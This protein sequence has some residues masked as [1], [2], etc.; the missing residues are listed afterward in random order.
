MAIEKELTPE[1]REEI[2]TMFTQG[3]DEFDI[4]DKIINLLKEK[5]MSESDAEEAADD[6]YD[7][8][9]ESDFKFKD[10][11]ELFFKYGG[12]PLTF[13]MLNS[14][15]IDTNKLEL[16]LKKLKITSNIEGKDE[17]GMIT[18]FNFIMYMA[19]EVKANPDIGGMLNDNIDNLVTWAGEK[20]E[21]KES[22]EV[23]SKIRI[24]FAKEVG[25]LPLGNWSNRKAMYEYWA[26]IDEKYSKVEE[27]YGKL[28][29]EIKGE[30]SK[31]IKY[32]VKLNPMKLDVPKSWHNA[33]KILKYFSELQGVYQVPR[34]EGNV[35]SERIPK[36]VT[37]ADVD[38]IFHYYY[39]KDY[40][41]LA[42]PQGQIDEIKEWIE[43]KQE[44]GKGVVAGLKNIGVSQSN[45]NEFDE[46]FEDF[47]R[48]AGRDEKDKT[49]NYFLPISPFVER[50]NDEY[51]NINT[52]LDGF[53]EELDKIL[54]PDEK[55]R[56]KFTT[57]QTSPSGVGRGQ[58]PATTQEAETAG[59]IMYPSQMGSSLEFSAEERKE[60]S[61]FYD[62][63]DAINEYYLIPVSSPY[64]VQQKEKPRWVKKHAAML[65][66]LISGFE[67]DESGE[68]KPKDPVGSFLRR[69]L[70]KGIHAVD[71][72]TLK[73]LTSFIKM[74]RKSGAT[75]WSDK[76]LREG[77]EAV[78][79]LDDLFG[80][81]WNDKNMQS[82]GNILFQIKKELDLSDEQLKESISKFPQWEGYIKPLEESITINYPL[83]K[84]RH[85]LNTPEFTSYLGIGGERDSKTNKPIYDI[86]DDLIQAYKE[87]DKEFD[88]FHKA[89][90]IN[91]S[92]LQA[93]DIIRKM[94]NE[95]IVKARLSLNSIT[96]MDLVINK[97]HKEKKMDLTSMEVNKIV[98]AV[99]SYQSIASDFG[100]NED[101]VYT[102][103]ALFR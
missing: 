91:L 101:A 44:E 66:S 27:K 28:P 58:G 76:F 8:L 40:S 53:F 45:I 26:K 35:V 97:L 93:H 39:N 23:K 10:E 80:P 59:A 16:R 29:E 63:L 69:S 34:K 15:K 49:T 21:Q 31:P 73:E 57:Y 12:Q 22:K 90:E 5:G 48:E 46:W 84:L 54:E 25:D 86:S 89:D 19:G 102:I 47:L 81:E 37:E 74:A 24:T 79:A 50:I 43:G 32:I 95:T 94:N 82:V 18:P 33:L 103:K 9:T 70:E 72:D 99:S 52:D 30:L 100:I 92:M 3:S 78:E 85:I 87:L 60:R 67:E 61:E 55:N 98:K 56:T 1:E 7:K 75:Y 64:F 13:D 68:R 77:L 6:I 20:Q 96:D 83:T 62:F 65:T 14:Q 51:K 2:D 42:I 71:V 38:P 41:K 4:T 17:D 88:D 36:V 11:I